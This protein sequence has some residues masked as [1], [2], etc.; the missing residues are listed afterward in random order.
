MRERYRQSPVPSRY[1]HILPIGYM[2]ELLAMGICGRL[3]TEEGLLAAVEKELTDKQIAAE[4]DDVVNRFH[5]LVD[6]E[7]I[8]HGGLSKRLEEAEAMA[9]D[10]AS[11]LFENISHDTLPSEF[12]D[13]LAASP[14]GA[15]ITE[16]QGKEQ[17][18][19]SNPIFQ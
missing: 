16:R 13:I 14:V 18:Y 15:Y 2:N 6:D 3:D 9:D 5:Q 17:E 11:F 7:M 1:R 4:P 12:T 19:F 10:T 8:L